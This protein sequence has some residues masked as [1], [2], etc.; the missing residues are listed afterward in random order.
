MVLDNVIINRIPLGATNYATIG[1]DRN[2]ATDCRRPLRNL[3]ARDVR[4]AVQEKR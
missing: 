4:S 3:L 2:T 1:D